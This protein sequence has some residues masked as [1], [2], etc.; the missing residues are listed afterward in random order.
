M[1]CKSSLIIGFKSSISH[2]LNQHLITVS[3]RK[4]FISAKALT[5]QRNVYAIDCLSDVQVIE[6]PC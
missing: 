1:R 5:G 3:S 4:H 6:E 2:S